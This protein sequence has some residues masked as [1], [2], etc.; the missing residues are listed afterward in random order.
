[1]TNDEA[2]QKLEALIKRTDVPNMYRETVRQAMIAAF[3]LGSNTA[4]DNPV[5]TYARPLRGD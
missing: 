5:P 4:D 1:M 3:V 2:M